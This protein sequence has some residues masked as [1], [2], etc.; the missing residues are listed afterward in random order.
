VL[1]VLPVLPVLSGP[2]DR[3]DCLAIRDR[4]VQPV[5][6]A[7]PAHK[8]QRAPQVLPGRRVRQEVR[9][10]KAMSVSRAR[11]D[12]SDLPDQLV[13]RDL[14]GLRGLRA[15]LDPQAFRE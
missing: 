13:P 15:K 9:G 5:R 8:G 3:R 12:L 6:L 11:P 10:T 2:R 1:P 7:L 14:R 4:R